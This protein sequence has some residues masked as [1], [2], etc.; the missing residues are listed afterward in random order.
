[1]VVAQF[2]DRMWYAGDPEY[3]EGTVSY[4]HNSTTITGSGT[5]WTSSLVGRYFYIKNPDTSFRSQYIV[6]AV[7]STTSLTL[8]NPYMGT[9]GSGLSYVI[10]NDPTT[11]AELFFCADEETEALTHRGW[12]RHGEILE[13]DLVLSLNPET[14]GRRPCSFSKSRNA[15]YRMVSAA[16]R[17]QIPV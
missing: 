9:S 17:K 5:N 3:D 1:M 11:R 10:A 12:K 13:D 4:T 14:Q 16:C 2:Q 15:G 8:D 7:N 6:S